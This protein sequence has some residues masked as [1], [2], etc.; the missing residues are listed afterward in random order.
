MKGQNVKLEQ[1]VSNVIYRIVSKI[2][3]IYTFNFYF[4]IKYTLNILTLLITWLFKCLLQLGTQLR[5]PIYT[6]M[7]KCLTYDLLRNIPKYQNKCTFWNL[8]ENSILETYFQILNIGN[9]YEIW[10]EHDPQK[11][12]NTLYGSK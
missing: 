11:W 5:I 3:L 8:R 1:N 7:L 6:K 2:M 9:M 10:V 12:E 4:I